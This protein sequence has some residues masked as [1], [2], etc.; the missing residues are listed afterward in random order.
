M[1]LENIQQIIRKNTPNLYLEEIMIDPRKV[2][3]KVKDNGVLDD[4]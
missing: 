4:L 3:W 1:G 2:R